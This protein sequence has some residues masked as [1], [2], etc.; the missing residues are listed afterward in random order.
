MSI[1]ALPQ[2]RPPKDVLERAFR[3]ANRRPGG[4]KAPRQALLCGVA[5]VTTLVGAF[6]C[7]TV[8]VRSPQKAPDWLLLAFLTLTLASLVLGLLTLRIAMH[9]WAV[10]QIEQLE[11]GNELQD[12][13]ERYD[14]LQLC[15]VS[16]LGVISEAD[17]PKSC[18]ARIRTIHEHLTLL[19]TDKMALEMEMKM[20]M[21]MHEKKAASTAQEGTPD[22]QELLDA[23][24]RKLK[25]V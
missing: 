6:A 17:V 9:A 1:E 19:Y 21:E 8:V 4:N 22:V 14:S 25:P 18:N 5:A 10:R 7:A 23:L 20:K 24:E 3:I 13:E 15:M 2:S 16:A 11:Q 12:L